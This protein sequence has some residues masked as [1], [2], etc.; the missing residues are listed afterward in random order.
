MTRSLP[1]IAILLLAF[2]GS[3]RAQT[4][5]LQ[6]EEATTA[7]AGRIALEAGLSLMGKEPNFLTDG[8]RTRLDAPVLGLVYSPAANVEIDLE[9]RGR[10]VA[11]DD[12]DY[13]TVSDWGDVTLRTKLR[14]FQDRKQSSAIAARFAL[15]LPET[16]QGKGLG[17]N[18]LRMSAQL[19]ATKAL[20]P[21]AVHA[22]LGLAIHDEVFTPHSQDDLFAYGLAVE[23]SVGAR[24]TLLGEIAGRAGSG[25]PVIERTHEARAGIRYSVRRLALDAAV[26][27]GLG[28]SDGEWG[29]TAGLTWTARVPR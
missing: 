24:L 4:R 5:P 8:Q 22:N 13:G 17:P 11:F 27:R 10:V 16:N 26:R 3:A 14:L 29:L 1:G 12:P 9:W 6:T 20:G 28:N 21:F 2:A 19:L 15:T 7:G 23:R 18:T 25:L